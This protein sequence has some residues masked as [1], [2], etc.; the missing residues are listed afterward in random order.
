MKVTTSRC[1]ER[2]R[3]KKERR[4]WEK[5]RTDF[6][7]SDAK[8]TSFEH[9]AYAAGGDALAEATDHSAADDHVFHCETSGKEGPKAILKT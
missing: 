3:R 8:A 1:T 4:N 9:D 6:D 5:E 2:R 7:G